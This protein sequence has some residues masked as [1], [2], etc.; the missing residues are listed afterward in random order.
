MHIYIH[1]FIC[2]YIFICKWIYIL[3]VHV[4]TCYIYCIYIHMYICIHIFIYVDVACTGFDWKNWSLAASCDVVTI[5][6]DCNST[7]TTLQLICSTCSLSWLKTF[8]IASRAAPTDESCSVLTPE[9]ILKSQLSDGK[10]CSWNIFWRW[11]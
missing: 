1:V 10:F 2:T 6:A 7:L 11:R 5:F 4:Y 8:F 9:E 3:Y